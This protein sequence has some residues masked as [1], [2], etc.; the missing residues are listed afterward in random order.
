MRDL[1]IL[2][3]H[4][5]VTVARL[6]GPGGAR[7]VVAE[8]LIVKHQRVIANR[9][10]TR[11]PRL[12]AIDRIIIGL[13][14]ILIRPRRL[15]RSAIVLK[16][17]TILAFHR[18]L[19]E[20][21]YRRL[22]T[23][24]NRR[25]PGPTGPSPEL[26]AV[27]VEMKR[28]NPRF[29]YQRTADQISLAFSIDVHKDVVRRVLERHYRPGAGSNGP[30][31]LTLLGHN[32]DSLWS[33]D[34]FRC[35][36][37][38]LQSHW[39]MVVMDQFTR[40]IIGFSVHAGPVDSLAVCRLFNR[41]LGTSPPPQILN[42]DNDPLFK[43]HRWKANLRV[44]DVKEVKTIPYV[45]ISHPFVERLIGTVRREFLDHVPF[46][47]ASDQERKLRSFKEYYNCD[48]THRGL[49][50]AVPGLQFANVTQKHPT[51]CIAQWKSRCRGLY[52]LP[53]AA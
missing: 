26:I 20:R 10:R 51:V 40:Q 16:P 9:S 5:L 29:G 34:L 2:L 52:Q 4:L 17:S 11:A 45:P 49:L 18:A 7:S 41:I 36:S 24:K 53:V 35:E 47:G 33:V 27:I 23:P 38:I 6:I 30:S 43:F 3:F 42:S 12:R 8:S 19:V 14:A 50:G 25:R 15:V 39:V 37:I 44:L 46:W 28:R 21:K 31:W 22:F 1:V 13:S 32:K 48:R